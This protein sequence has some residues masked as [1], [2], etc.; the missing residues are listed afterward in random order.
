MVQLRFPFRSRHA[1]TEVTMRFPVSESV[2]VCT[3][4]QPI[5]RGSPGFCRYRLAME[6]PSFAVS[7]EPQQS[8]A[9]RCPQSAIPVSLIRDYIADLSNCVWVQLI[10][11]ACIYD[12]DLPGV[13]ELL[14]GSTVRAARPVISICRTPRG[15]DLARH[16]F[17]PRS[18]SASQSGCYSASLMH[19]VVC[20]PADPVPRLEQLETVDLCLQA[21]IG[22][23]IES[24]C[25]SGA[26][27]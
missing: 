23:L 6:P 7:H 1:A 12:S 26:V 8:R 24:G 27:K 3:P 5:S 18:P 19:R 2:A 16:Q 9:S 20:C 17:A 25:L 10:N 22:G 14:E 4:S 13:S 15:S 11:H 21:G